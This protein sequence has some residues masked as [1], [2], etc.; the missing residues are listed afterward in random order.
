MSLP[1]MTTCLVKATTSAEAQDL[2]FCLLLAHSDCP[3]MTCPKMYA[4][5][6]LKS[7]EMKC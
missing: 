5:L 1:A 6:S 7:L 3:I 2:G 4:E